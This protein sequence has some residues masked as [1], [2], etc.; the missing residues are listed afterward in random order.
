MTYTFMHKDIPVADIE[1]YEHSGTITEI[2]NE[3]NTEHL[4]VGV[5]IHNNV[6]DRKELNAWWRERSIPAQRTDI[7]KLLCGLDIKSIK[8]LVIFS[9]GLSL[10]DCYW[11]KPVGSEIKWEEINF[12]DNPFSLDMGDMLLDIIK[13]N[14]N[15][16]L[17]SPDNTTE[18]CLKKRW[19]ITDDKRYLVK[20]GEPPYYQ[21]PF[22]EV[23]ASIIM[24]RLG[25]AHIPY[26]LTWINGKPYSVCEDFV[27]PDTELVSAWKVL[28]VATK[29]NHHN[30]FLHYIRICEENKI[31]NIRRALDEMIVV[32]YLIANE[33]RHLNNFGIIRNADTLE[34]IR[35]APIFDSGTSLGFNKTNSNLCN[36][37]ICKPFKKSHGEQLGLVSSF[38]WIDFDK[39]N[40]VENDIS[41]LMS[42]KEA[43]AVLGEG[44][45][46]VIADF[47]G[48]RIKKLKKYIVSKRA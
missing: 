9:N 23:I 26:T 37:I 16:N 14:N 46:G 7:N 4:P 20:A 5:H 35:P 39:L 32:D 29:Y 24:N 41:D 38:E 18:G 48:E 6:I 44:R 27:T 19:T 10:S 11:V 30:D 22:N 33:D 40:G 21:Q 17:C 47:V 12:F 15:L 28:Q 43:V 34:W 31:K 3:Y 42:T 2:K 8:Q 36:K 25:I 45:Y 1:I 13:P